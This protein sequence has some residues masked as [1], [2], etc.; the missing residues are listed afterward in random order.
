MD[1][2]FLINFKI[3]IEDLKKGFSAN[4]EKISKEFEARFPELL[5]MN[6]NIQALSEQITKY[7]K[8]ME[9]TNVR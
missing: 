2:E 4:M 1:K 5:K 6:V 8:K 3:D 7:Q 9:K